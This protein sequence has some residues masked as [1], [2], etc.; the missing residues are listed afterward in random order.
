ME[1]KVGNRIRERRL[2]LGLSQGKLARAIGTDQSKV[3]H[4]EAGHCEPKV[5]NALLLAK[6]LGTTVE[7]LFAP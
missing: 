5:F 3:S 1:N 6:A 4:W 2:E 7:Y